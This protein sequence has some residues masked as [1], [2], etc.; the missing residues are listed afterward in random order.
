MRSF[1]VNKNDEGQRLDKFI[2]KVVRGMPPSLMYK[3]IRKKRIKVNGKRADEKYRLSLGD[4]VEMYIPDEF[5]SGNTSA[6]EYERASAELDVVYEDENL[7]L[8]NKRPGLLVHT[9]DGGDPNTTPEAERETLIFMI[10]AYLVS[11]GEYRP[12]DENSFTPALCNRIDRNTGGI[13]IAAKNAKTLRAVNEAIRAREVH[14]YYLCAVHGIPERREAVLR[15]YLRK[16]HRTNTVEVSDRR[17]PGSKEIITGYRVVAEN[18]RDDL[19][20]LEI[21]LMTG[22]THQIRAHMASIGHPLL[23]DGK[24]GVNGADRKRGYKYQALYSYALEFA[25]HSEELAY[26]YGR[27]IEV[28]PSSV[29]FLEKFPGFLPGRE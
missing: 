9:G 6:A 13:V 11:K 2:T 24:Y 1:T 7:L 15:G 16:N 26:M 3:Y 20:L 8:V 14:K 29:F 18:N 5:F 27:R 21:S 19:A 28:D 10:K 25:S 12:E 17:L 4:I 22:R 23:G